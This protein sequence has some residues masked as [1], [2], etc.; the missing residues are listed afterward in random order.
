MNIS[1]IANS[2]IQVYKFQINIDPSADIIKSLG[3]WERFNTQ[4]MKISLEF[5]NYLPDQDIWVSKRNLVSEGFLDERGS[6]SENINYT[7]LRPLNEDNEYFTI[8]DILS[9]LELFENKWI[10]IP[11][12]KS[13]NA[14]DNIFGPTDWARLYLKPVQ[15]DKNRIKVYDAI[16]A[17]DTLLSTAPSDLESPYLFEN[18]NDNNFSLC[19]N[20]DLVLNF[21]DTNFNCGWVEDYLTNIVHGSKDKIPS[22][23]P[24]L[25]YLGYYIYFIKYL[26]ALKVFPEV[27][28]FSDQT[29]GI[30][31]DLV[32][33]IGNANTCGLLFESP[34]NKSFEFTSV[35]KL[36]IQD[37]TNVEK[38]YSDP[39]S[40]LLAFSKST[41]GEIGYNS[42]KFQ[43]PSVLRVGEEAKFLIN[44]SVIDISRGVEIATHHSSPK[45][46]LWDDKKSANQ[47]E[48]SRQKGQKN[49]DP[50]YLRG[51]SEQFYSDG[52]FSRNVDFGATS[53]FSK[54]SLMT[55]VYLEILSHA[56]CQINSHEF[57]YEHGNLEKPRKLKRVLIT[58][59]TAMVQKEQIALRQCA[60]E[61]AMVLKRYY[62]NTYEIEVETSELS[63]DIE[64]M[65]SVRDL[66]KDLSVLATRK[67]WIYDEATCCQLV[68]LYGEI[69]KRYLNKC[70][71]FFNLYGKKSA[72]FENYD[73]NAITIGSVDIGAGTTDLMICTYQYDETGIA[74]LTPKPL[75]WES[76]NLA[77]DEFLH[78]I[79][80]QIIL[81]GKLIKEEDRGCVGVIE[82]HARNIGIPNIQDKMNRFYGTDSNNI[83]HIGRIM[84]KNFN[85][86]IS[87]P[88]ALRYLSHAQSSKADIY[89][90]YQ[91]I[92]DKLQPNPEILHYF[93]IHFGFKFEDIRWKLSSQRV[94]DILESTFEPLLKQISAL[95]FAYGCDFILLAGKP[96]SLVRIEE[97]FLKFY[98]VSPDKIITLNHYRVGR[99]YPFADDSGYFKDPKSI[100][101]VGALISLMGG[102]LDKLSGF[103]LNT[104]FLKTKIISTADYLGVYDANTKNIHTIIL[105][106]EENR[107][108]L[109]IAGLP[110]TI[111]LKQLKPINYPGRPIY[112]LDFNTQKIIEK[113]K[114]QNQ[115]ITENELSDQV[116]H[117]KM[118]LKNKMPFKIRISRHFRENKE[119]IIIDSIVDKDRNE[120]SPSILSLS[121]QTLQNEGNYWLDT[122]EFT[123]SIRD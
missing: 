43:W 71:I 76:F 20:E 35:K 11:Y 89:V 16:L 33:D 94:N 42:N 28:L 63:K 118:L 39:F 14:G 81:E 46:Y 38:S 49:P 72:Y 107:S 54:K 108:D 56:L 60:E 103:R 22:A 99:W 51:I 77:G 8:N 30:E 62:S 40:M 52:Q 93:S 113:I 85:T 29:L 17:F 98:P 115:S 91:E 114:D 67:D 104:E 31:V 45:R 19:K 79:I 121:V 58:C 34:M 44:N 13:N 4:S 110:I 90:S 75:Y 2:G 78:E 9:S 59:P 53:N 15:T 82:N 27:E 102:R 3:F 48:Y 1:L 57:R 32:L 116:S 86:Q 73:K 106:P 21:C 84:R 23:F 122:G 96:T 7:L 69:S 47:W 123:L 97:L 37:L 80:R 10:P 64:I 95:A 105:S 92:F 112:L 111:G 65:P 5:A 120:L 74:V 83:G 12:F 25:K 26:Q 6:L 50:V 66:S 24:S 36:K 119:K 100:V 41:F 109:I 68:F 18:V 88:I 70:D 87:L 55:F 101:S 117:Y 61:A